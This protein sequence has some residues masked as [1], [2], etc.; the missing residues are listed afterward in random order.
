MN[1][2]TAKYI[3]EYAMAINDPSEQHDPI[4]SLWGERIVIPVKGSASFTA[5]TNADSIL[6]FMSPNSLNSGTL[7]VFV[8]HRQGQST[9]LKSEKLALDAD[10]T[11]YRSAAPVSV[12]LRAENSSPFNNRAGRQTQSTMGFLPSSLAGLTPTRLGRLATDKGDVTSVDSDSVAKGVVICPDLGRYQQNT[13]ADATNPGDSFSVTSSSANGGSEYTLAAVVASGGSATLVGSPAIQFNSALSSLTNP[14]NL[15]TTSLKVSVD[16][17]VKCSAGGVVSIVVSVLDHAGATITS[18][19]ESFTMAAVEG[20]INHDFFIK[21]IARGPNSIKIGVYSDGTAALDAPD[22]LSVSILAEQSGFS[23]D[24]NARNIIA[25]I[26]AG[27]NAGATISISMDSLLDVLPGEA[28]LSTFSMPDAGDLE[29]GTAMLQ[30]YNCIGDFNVTMPDSKEVFTTV[31]SYAPKYEND[32]MNRGTVSAKSIGSF[33]RG[34]GRAGRGA[35][36][37]V[38]RHPGEI[39]RGAILGTRVGLAVATEN[40]GFL[41]GV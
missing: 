36:N 38:K 34:L 40:P 19:T 29:R 10:S 8:L 5:A 25:G 20:N 28:A 30:I 7:S 4:V 23:G 15:F 18:E 27:V 39:K 3:T 17:G 41:A 6:Y 21:K 11:N 12:A 32:L 37:F 33:F 26:F 22:N 13:Q 31:R 35:V 14:I 1:T 24:A 9:I 2:A 16:M